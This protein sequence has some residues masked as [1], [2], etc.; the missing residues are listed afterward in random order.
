MKKKM[1]KMKRSRGFGQIEEKATTTFVWF[2][3][4]FLCGIFC[5]AGDDEKKKKKEEAMCRHFFVCSCRCL[6][7]WGVWQ[8][9]KKGKRKKGFCRLEEKKRKAFL[10]FLC[11][12]APPLCWD[13]HSFYRKM[14]IGE[15]VC[16]SA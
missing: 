5:F 13:E 10:H 9:K 16:N 8:G 14:K 3:E 1:M 12:L 4:L 15:Q 7:S 6:F 11:S 2:L